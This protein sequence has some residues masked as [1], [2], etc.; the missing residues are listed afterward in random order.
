VECHLIRSLASVGARGI[1][2]CLG[3]ML[4]AG[5][6]RVRVSDEVDFS[7]DLNIPVSLWPRDRL[8]L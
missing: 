6:S 2:V 5:R 4:Q 3:T 7:V 1:V 8:S